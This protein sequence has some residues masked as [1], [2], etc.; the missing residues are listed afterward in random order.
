MSKRDRILDFLLDNGPQ[1]GRQISKAFPPGSGHF[2]RLVQEGSVF[3][4]IEPDTYAI[5]AKAAGEVKTRRRAA[6]QVEGEN[7]D[8]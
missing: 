7:H 6:A 1:T 4:L 3:V 5:S 2:A 8:D